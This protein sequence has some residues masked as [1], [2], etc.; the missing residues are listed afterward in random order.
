M[1]DES[2][3]IN[4]IVKPTIYEKCRTTVRMEPFLVVRGRLQKD[5]LTAS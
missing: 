5:G 3:P 2:G 1:E 4:V